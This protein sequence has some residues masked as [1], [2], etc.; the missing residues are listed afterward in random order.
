MASVSSLLFLFVSVYHFHNIPNIQ[1]SYTTFLIQPLFSGR[2]S[3]YHHLHCIVQEFWGG[4]GGG[5]V[6]I[7]HP[8]APTVPYPSPRTTE[9][10]RKGIPSA[11]A[12][13]NTERYILLLVVPQ[14][15]SIT[16]LFS[17]QKIR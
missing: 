1:S 10:P 9:C 11:T 14:C 6:H 12:M 4:D 7:C 8:S 15:C 13:W 17:E 2:L 16:H 5:R 3:L